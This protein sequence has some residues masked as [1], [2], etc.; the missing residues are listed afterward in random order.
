MFRLS[1]LL[2]LWSNF[3]RKIILNGQKFRKFFSLC[4]N[5][6]LH[7]NRSNF[8]SNQLDLITN[9]TYKQSK[10]SKQSYRY[11]LFF[12]K[13]SIARY[14]TITLIVY[15]WGRGA[16]PLNRIEWRTRLFNPQTPQTN[17]EIE[18]QIQSDRYFSIL[19]KSL[20]FLI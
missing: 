10:I 7:L 3:G 5:G 19:A 11:F 20:I 12:S 6:V 13:T 18:E 8:L 9:G 17:E 14:K 15:V 4:G 16:L 2:S 1:Y